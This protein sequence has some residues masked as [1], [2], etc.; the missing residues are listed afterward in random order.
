M[1]AWHAMIL[2]QQVCMAMREGMKRF[3]TPFL[4]TLRAPCFTPKR[5][6]SF[7]NVCAGGQR[8]EPLPIMSHP[9]PLS[10]LQKA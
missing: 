1:R 7:T 10:F 8:A 9:A 2:T 6:V 4:P 3:P 5:P